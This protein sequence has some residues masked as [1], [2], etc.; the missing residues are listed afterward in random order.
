MNI[1]RF[2]K[3]TFQDRFWHL[4]ACQ[5][6]PK[7]APKTDNK[8]N[9]RPP[10]GTHVR[11]VKYDVGVVLELVVEVLEVL[12]ILEVALEVVLEVLEVVLE[13][14]EVLVV[15]VLLVVRGG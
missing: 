8:K 5:D 10:F 1:A 11:T 6:L 2:E 15:V 14:L 13:I 3:L 4:R 9:Q 7:S 12:E